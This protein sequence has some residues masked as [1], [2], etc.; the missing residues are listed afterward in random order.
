MSTLILSTGIVLSGVIATIA[1][2]RKMEKR[3]DKNGNS[4]EN[5]NEN[6]EKREFRDF[7]GG[8]LGI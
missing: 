1:Y 2:A 6:D 7:S 3:D 5:N 8:L 4:P